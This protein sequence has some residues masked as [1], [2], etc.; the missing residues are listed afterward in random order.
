MYPGPVSI[1]LEMTDATDHATASTSEDAK[2]SINGYRRAMISYTCEQVATLA[3]SSPQITI[4]FAD[5]K[6]GLQWDRQHCNIKNNL[7]ERSCKSHGS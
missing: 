4:S 6:G 1:T 7:P 5:G 3:I 2:R